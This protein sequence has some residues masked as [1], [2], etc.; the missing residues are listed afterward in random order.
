RQPTERV[1][2]QG[3][4]NSALRAGVCGLAAMQGGHKLVQ[5]DSPQAT[6]QHRSRGNRP[7]I[8]PGFDIAVWGLTP[9]ASCLQLYT[10]RREQCREQLPAARPDCVNW[11]AVAEYDTVTAGYPGRH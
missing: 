4:G 10:Y 8:L 5:S 3:L 9:P 1:S 7:R 2:R 6:C 11:V